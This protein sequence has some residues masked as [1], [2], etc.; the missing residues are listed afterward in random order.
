MIIEFEDGEY[1]GSTLEMPYVMADG[2]TTAACVDATLEALT[3]AVA[4]L[5]END[6]EPPASSSDNKRSEQVNV[7]LTAME[8][9]RLEEASR[10]QGFRGLS[11]YIRNKALE[12]A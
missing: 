3:T 5:L 9:M 10:R 2:K 7:R 4:T 11:D 1:Y 8:K 6:Q 12:G